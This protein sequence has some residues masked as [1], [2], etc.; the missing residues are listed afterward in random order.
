MPG[1]RGQGGQNGG[2]WLTGSTPVYRQVEACDKVLLGFEMPPPS[3]LFHPVCLL[4]RIPRT[5][6][7]SA[8]KLNARV[9][10]GGILFVVETQ[11][12]VELRNP[13]LQLQWLLKEELG[14][15]G[16]E[17]GW[18]GCPV[19]VEQSLFSAADLLLQSLV[20]LPQDPRPGEVL[21]TARK[22]RRAIRFPILGVELMGKLVEHDVVTIVDV[23]RSG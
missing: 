6:L 17:L 20:F 7:K 21:G 23:R 1:V 15:H 10:G 19:P 12:V 2:V 13:S 3:S 5:S 16:K 18:I 14:C 22:D 4:Q 11:L 8:E 9:K